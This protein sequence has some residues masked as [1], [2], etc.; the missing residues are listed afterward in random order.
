M[1]GYRRGERGSTYEGQHNAADVSES[2]TKA[3]P[4]PKYGTEERNVV[5]VVQPKGHIAGLSALP[6][7]TGTSQSPIHP[8]PESPSHLQ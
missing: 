8:Y 5:A 4:R 7:S 6:I 2:R 3:F 1:V